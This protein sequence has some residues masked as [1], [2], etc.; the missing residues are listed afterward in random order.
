MTNPNDS[1]NRGRYRFQAG[2]PIDP[3]SEIDAESVSCVPNSPQELISM[4]ENKSDYPEKTERQRSE[5]VKEIMELIDKLDT[6]PLDDQQIAIALISSLE[7]YHDGIVDQMC[8]DSDAKHSQIV[9][10]AVDADRLM[11]CRHMLSSVDLE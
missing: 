7:Q 8:D 2:K 5:K 6:S 9:S 4:Q 1:P 3:N 10:W 11:H